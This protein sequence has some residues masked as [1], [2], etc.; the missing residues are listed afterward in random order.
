MKRGLV[1]IKLYVC[2]SVCQ[3]RDLWQNERQLCPDIWKIIYPSFLRRISS[4]SDP[5][6]QVNQKNPPYD[7]WGLSWLKLCSFVNSRNI[8]IKL[9]DKVYIW[10]LNN[11]VKFR[12][13]IPTHCCNI[14]KSRRGDFFWFTWYTNFG[15]IL[16]R[17]VSNLLQ[18]IGQIFVVDR[19][20]FSI[21]ICS[22]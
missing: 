6:Y 19:E 15:Y 18:S 14:N 11:H 8:S 21:T 4:G 7:F 3:T 22:G 12:T 17:A 1:T 5:F 10:S 13:K 2:P 16:P 9:G 20:C